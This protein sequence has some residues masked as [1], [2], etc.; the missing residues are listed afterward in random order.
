MNWNED[1]FAATMRS[2]YP[3][4]PEKHWGTYRAIAMSLNKETPKF[5]DIDVLLSMRK[6]IEELESSIAIK[7][8]KIKSLEEELRYEK[9]RSNWDNCDNVQ[10]SPNGKIFGP[11]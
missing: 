4:V 7:D 8:R 11:G 5:R 2:L 6:K 9:S 10:L 3:G 1:E